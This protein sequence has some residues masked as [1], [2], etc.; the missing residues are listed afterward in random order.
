MSTRDVVGLRI[1]LTRPQPGELAERLQALGAVVVHVPLIDV[2][3]AADGGAALRRALA[4]LGAFDWLVV[5]SANGARRVGEAAQAH[6]GV[7]LAAV[8][9]ATAD[10]LAASAGR[11]TDLIPD[12][13]R[14]EGLL[15]AFPRWPSRVLLAQA[16]RAGRLLADGLT[17][18]GH[19]VE[20]VV[21]YRTVERPPSAQE[22]AELRRADVVVLASGSAAATYARAVGRAQTTIVAIGPVTAQAART[23]GLVVDHIAPSPDTDALLRTMGWSGRGA[24]PLT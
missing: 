1:A 5:T 8:G 21:A 11:P 4:R 14:A 13:A 24:R 3:D 2:A 7:R 15:A 9:P 20:S 17:A 6:P 22:T 10:A 18:A 12:V 19:D 23:H 16:D